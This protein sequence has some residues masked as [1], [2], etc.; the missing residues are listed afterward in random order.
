MSGVFSMIV[1]SAVGLAVKEAVTI[2]TQ[3]A[4]QSLQEGRML[5]TRKVKMLDGGYL[6]IQIAVSTHRE[7]AQEE[8]V[9]DVE[10]S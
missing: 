9:A 8:L 3:S 4:A 10:Q 5:I 1:K 7:P 2:G 6:V